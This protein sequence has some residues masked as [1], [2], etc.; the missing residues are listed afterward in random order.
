MCIRDSDICEQHKKKTIAPKH[1]N[2]GIRA[3][4][5]FQKLISH[6]TIAAGSVP[7]KVHEDLE[8]KA[9]GKKRAPAASQ[10]V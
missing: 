6:V 7:V 3:D 8:K 4:E 10:A 1:I 9:K 5:E 2:L